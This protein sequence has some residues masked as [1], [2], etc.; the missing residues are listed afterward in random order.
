MIEGVGRLTLA[1]V[2]R[3]LQPQ[4]RVVAAMALQGGVTARVVKLTVST[5][6][7]RTRGLVL[8]SFIDVVEASDWLGREAGALR[9]LAKRSGVV[10]PGL[11]AVDP[12]GEQCEW[13]S[14]LMTHLPG[15]VVLDDEGVEERLPVLARQ[16]VAI[17]GVQPRERPKSFVT[18]STAETAVVPAGADWS[19]AIDVIRRPAPAYVGRFLHRDFQP[20]NVLFEGQRITGVVDWAGT[21]WGPAELDV[22]HCSTNLAL[23]HGPEWGLRFAEAYQEAGGELANRRYWFVRDAL[24]ASEEISRVS[25]PWREAGRMEL[26]TACLEQRLSNYIATLMESRARTDEP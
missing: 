2:E 8:R 20:G 24:A 1:W 15:R 13:P 4:E 17:H 9:T 21:S 23:L 25:Q 26:T 10:A 3:Q 12:A 6:D 16:L 11:V 19:E 14:L 5:G 18:L 22:S 7:G